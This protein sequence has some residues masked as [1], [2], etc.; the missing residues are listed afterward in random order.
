MTKI[1]RAFLKDNPY[2]E[3]SQY[4]RLVSQISTL[5]ESASAYRIGITYFSS[6]GNRLGEREIDLFQRDITYFE[7]NPSLL[8]GKGEYNKYLRDKYQEALKQKQ[9]A[10]YERVNAI[11]D[12]VNNKNR[13][14][15]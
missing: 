8:M 9:H 4:Y 12:F 10:Y 6:A 14:C 1:L 2:K 11:V 13:F 15:C 5:I 3:R 7:E